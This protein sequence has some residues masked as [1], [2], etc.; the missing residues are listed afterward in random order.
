MRLRH[1]RR[2]TVQRRPRRRLGVDGVGLA[3]TTSHLAIR[4]VHFKYLDAL[5]RQKGV[6]TGAVRTGA[7]H[8]DLREFAETS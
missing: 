3:A 8:T 4:S 6:Q 7:L 5:A 1:D 2:L